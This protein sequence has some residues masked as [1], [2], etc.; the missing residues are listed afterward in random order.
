MMLD[1]DRKDQ[2]NKLLDYR[3]VISDAMLHIETILQTH[4]PEE[5][6]IGYQHYIPQIITALYDDDRWLPRGQI[7]LQNTIDRILDNE[8]GHTGVSKF[9]K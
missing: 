3:D 5:F 2:V 1:Q 7:T 8:S 9:T 6:D 4:F